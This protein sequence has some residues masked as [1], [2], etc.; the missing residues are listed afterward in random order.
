MCVSIMLDMRR[1]VLG[2]GGRIASQRRAYSATVV[3]SDGSTY[4]PLAKS[5][6]MLA[7][8]RRPTPPAVGTARRGPSSARPSYAGMATCASTAAVPP[9]PPT[10][11]YPKHEAAPT[12]C[13]TSSPPADRATGGRARGFLIRRAD[14]PFASPTLCYRSARLTFGCRARPA[15]SLRSASPLPRSEAPGARTPGCARRP[16]TNPPDHT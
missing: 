9:P 14:D 12:T 6:A 5:A 13:P 15:S 11:S 4:V 16:E 10:T 2:L 3:R 7:T 1:A 8:R